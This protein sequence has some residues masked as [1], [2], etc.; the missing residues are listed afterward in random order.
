MCHVEKPVSSYDAYVYRGVEQYRLAC[1]E[2][3]P[4]PDECIECGS[5]P[6][7]ASFAWRLLKSGPTYRSTCSKCRSVNKDG[8]SHSQASRAKLK[9][10]D[11]EGSNRK[12]AENQH[13]HREK[14]K[15]TD[16]DAHRV[17]RREEQRRYRERKKAKVQ[18]TTA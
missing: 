11:P 10:D 3:V 16:L 17:A 5:K 15:A 6:P 9:A 18:D 13:R 2:C 1:K 4:L 8:V 7:E 14:K 12:N